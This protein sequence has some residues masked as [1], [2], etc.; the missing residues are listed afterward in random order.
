MIV[1][2]TTKAARAPASL[3]SYVPNVVSY[4]TAPSTSKVAPGNSE[5]ELGAIHP[6]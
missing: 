5:S 2:R 6:F 3:I 4:S 1:P